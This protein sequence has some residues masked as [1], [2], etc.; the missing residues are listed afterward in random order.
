[1]HLGRPS[2][3]PPNVG[4]LEA[5]SGEQTCGHVLVLFASLTLHDVVSQFET[6][7]SC[8]SWEFHG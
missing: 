8:M 3:G 7:S 1:M 6:V 4:K 2:S 5:F